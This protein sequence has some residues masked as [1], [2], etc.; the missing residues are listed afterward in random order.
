MNNDLSSFHSD[1]PA[2]DEN[3]LGETIITLLVMALTFLYHGC[4]F[5][6]SKKK[7]KNS[8]W[9]MPDKNDETAKYFLKIASRIPRQYFE[10]I[11]RPSFERL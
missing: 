3:D 1:E 10:I 7:E 6:I 9:Y 2:K 4:G 5:A 11:T 8:G